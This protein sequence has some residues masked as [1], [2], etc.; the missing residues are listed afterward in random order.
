MDIVLHDGVAVV[1]GL[2]LG[3]FAQT[4]H[5]TSGDFEALIC[6]VAGYYTMT[7]C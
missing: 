3:L 4:L 5:S 6:A 2:S 1:H 7:G